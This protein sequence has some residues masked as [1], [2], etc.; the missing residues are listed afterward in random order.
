[1]RLRLDIGAIAVR[2]G[3]AGV[4]LL[5]LSAVG[6]WR[7]SAAGVQ[8]GAKID[9]AT[10]GAITGKVMLQGTPPRNEPIRMNAD[11]N[12]VKATEGQPQLQETYMV[13]AGGGLQNVFVYVKE[14]LGK[15][16]YDKPAASVTLD[17][18]QCRYHPHVFGI[19][20]GQPLEIVN[21]DMTLHNI[22]SMPDENTEF[23]IGQPQQG[24]KTSRTFTA[25]E[26]MV[27]IRCDVHGWMN[28]YAGVL[29]HPFFAVSGADGSFEIKGLPPGKYTIEAW[30]ERLPAMTQQVAIGAKESRQVAFTFKVG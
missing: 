23:N 25:P 18:R 26:V 10:A 11:P 20:V 24:M 5:S 3:L 9:R 22:H 4:V 7:A 17:Q 14:G 27:P 28:A 13:G 12:C 1:M 2:F 16:S 30:H 19:R 8:G 15:F 21:S 6:S 29:D